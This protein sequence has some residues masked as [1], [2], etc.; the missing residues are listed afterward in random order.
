[1]S[2]HVFKASL[3]G[4]EQHPT[5][6]EGL[7]PDL[8]RYLSALLYDAQDDGVPPPGPPSPPR[9]PSTL[10]ADKRE[11]YNRLFHESY[12]GFHYMVHPSRPRAASRY[13]S[14]MPVR[15]TAEDT[16]R[17]MRQMVTEVIAADGD[18]GVGG[19]DG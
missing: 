16:E 19:G 2:A 13:L 4:A 18:G 9:R 3:S 1:M 15:A 17:K 8:D 10:E 7:D 5:S 11:P 6:R 14:F 12:G